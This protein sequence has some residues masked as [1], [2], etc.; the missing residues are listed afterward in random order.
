MNHNY[1]TEPEMKQY[2]SRNLKK[3]RNGRTPPISQQQLAD[4]LHVDRGLIAKYESGLMLPSICLAVN[5]ARC[6]DTTVEH[7]FTMEEKK[8]GRN[9]FENVTSY[10]TKI[11]SGSKIQNYG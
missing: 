3:L 11:D 7:L 6:F 10:H 5:I 8:E 9:L 1:I 2:F 4:R